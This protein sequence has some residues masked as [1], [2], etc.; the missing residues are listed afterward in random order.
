MVNREMNRLRV[1]I[2]ALLAAL[3]ISTFGA[4]DDRSAM[5][6]QVEGSQSGGSG[7]LAALS[8]ADAMKQVRVPGVS[9]AVIRDSAVHW[10]KGYA[11][12]TSGPT[13]P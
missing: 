12:P 2:L 13:G 3:T 5:Q 6:A 4:Q 9:I 10:A 1:G 11:S 8:L 7:E